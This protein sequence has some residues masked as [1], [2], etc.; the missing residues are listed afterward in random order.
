M[1]SPVRQHKDNSLHR[2]LQPGEYILIP[3]N[4]TR[5]KGGNFRLSIYV[6]DKIDESKGV[7]NF[8]NRLKKVYV[9]KLP[10]EKDKDDINITP[11]LIREYSKTEIE[12]EKDEK[13]NILVYQL[14][15][16]LDS[17]KEE[18]KTINTEVK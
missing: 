17:Q 12:K 4:C 6:E 11:V 2:L 15:R 13:K 1:I 10:N 16:A 5:G 14:K 18:E 7:I 8:M 9:C 3:C